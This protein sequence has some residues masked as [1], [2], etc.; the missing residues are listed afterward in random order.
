MQ[1]PDLIRHTVMTL[2]DC[3][4][5]FAAIRNSRNE[6]EIRTHLQALLDIY[7]VVS[8]ELGRG[9]VFWRGRKAGSAPFNKATQMSYPPVECTQAQRL[10]DLGCPC[11]YGATRRSTV[12]SE[13]NAQVGECYQFVGFRVKPSGSL[14][15]GAIGELSH[16]YKTGYIKS[17]GTDPDNALSRFLNSKGLE[18]GKQLVYID[19]FLASILADRDAYQNDYL[20]TRILAKLSYEKS[21][22]SGLFYP[23]VQESNGMNVAILSEPYL[24]QT[25]LVCCQ[26]VKIKKVREF[27]IFDYHVLLEGRGV[28]DEG[29][30]MWQTP[31][32]QFITFFG[33]TEREQKFL[34][35]RPLNDGNALIELAKLS[36]NDS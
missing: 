14:R 28:D 12:L 34:Q 25:H 9:S 20:H 24:S 6:V 35:N 21:G 13:L 3:A 16:I 19:A 23:S 4:D 32:E 10:N 11:L 8:F 15:V 5:H 27:G 2:D 26:Y 1:G 29:T 17:L 22:A 33:L 36:R 7:P 18:G 31:K 30:I